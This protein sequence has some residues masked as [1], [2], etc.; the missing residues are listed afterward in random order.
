MSTQTTC[1]LCGWRKYSF[2]QQQPAIWKMYFNMVYC[3]WS[4]VFILFFVCI[5]TDQIQTH[6]IVAQSAANHI[7][8]PAVRDPTQ[9]LCS[10]TSQVYILNVFSFKVKHNHIL[11]MQ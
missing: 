10:T 1:K 4:C 5:S 9:S 11:F 6:A 3:L 2:W 8:V 7:D